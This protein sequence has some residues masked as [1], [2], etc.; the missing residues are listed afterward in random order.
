MATNAVGKGTAN[1]GVN[2]LLKEKSILG[3]L[4]LAEDRSL[5]DFIRRQTIAG[6]RVMYPAE[7]QA[8]ED[9]RKK[10]NEQMLLSL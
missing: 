2:L 1:V 5:S 7:A 10:H 4:A 9:A 3:R 8:M 6:L